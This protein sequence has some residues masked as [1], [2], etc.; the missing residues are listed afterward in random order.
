MTNLI[1]STAPVTPVVRQNTTAI[2]NVYISKSHWI[3][4]VKPIVYMVLG[5]I[6]MLMFFLLT[7]W[8]RY[9]IAV[10][11][12]FF[13]L[14]AL[15]SYIHYKTFKIVLRRNQISI[16]AGWITSSQLDIPIYRREG[17]FISQN[18]LG[19]LLNYGK[20]TI[21]T[22]GVSATHT[23]SNPNELRQ[24]LYNQTI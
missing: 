23:I 20:I 3:S 7:S 12:L 17:V 4:F 21:S 11:S 2:E 13:F 5:G 14:G 9:T 6:G 10:P 8:F 15:N 18:I 1:Q 24:E 22:G 16:S 19:K